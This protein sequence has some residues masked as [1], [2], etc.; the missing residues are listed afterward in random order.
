MSNNIKSI[1]A[2]VHSAAPGLLG[3]KLVHETP[4]GLTSGVIVETEAYSSDDPASHTYRGQTPRNQVMFG[5]AGYVY[6][7]F[8]YGIHYCFNVVTGPAGSGQA[9]LIRAVE[10]IDGVEL[11]KQRRGTDNLHQLT[12]GP[13]KLVQA[14]GITKTDYGANLL[15]GGKLRLEPGVVPTKITQ[16]TRVGI[17]Q[18]THQP[19][20]FYI[21]GNQ[22]VSKPV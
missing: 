22:F 5:P 6:V 16:T 10:P 2:D 21:A 20:R 19:W 1:L 8:T 14:M 15:N 18:A 7:Y 17:K 3:Y 9:V 4:E 13:A 12:N 11:M